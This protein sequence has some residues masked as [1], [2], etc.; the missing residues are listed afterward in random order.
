MEE[1]EMVQNLHVMFE[2]AVPMLESIRQAFRAQNEGVL[3]E[4]EKTF[5]EIFQSGL[6]LTEAAME[7][8]GK[9][10]AE[11]KFALLLIPLQKIAAAIMNLIGRRKRIMGENLFFTDKAVGEVEGLLLLLKEQF[12][13]T[14]DFIATGNPLL[15]NRIETLCSQIA[16]A[17]DHDATEH[18]NRLVTGLCSPKSSYY[19]LEI[20][21]S[22]KNIS[23]NLVDLSEKL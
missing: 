14:R 8:K 9:S 20:V 5:V 12:V 23:R 19:Y 13:D 16:Q 11:K 17:A 6:P 21:D 3:T 22:F 2:R 15:K 18:Q 7:K 4:A 1:K 10:S